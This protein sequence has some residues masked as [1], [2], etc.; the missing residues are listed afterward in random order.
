MW[1]AWAALDKLATI[2][3]SNLPDKIKRDF[4][5]ATVEFVLIYGASTW[6]LTKRLLTRL[7]GTYTRMLRVVL[8]ISWR[9][10]PTKLR[11]YGKVPSLSNTI[12]K[13]RMRFAGHSFRSKDELVSEVITWQ[14]THGKANVGRPHK[15]YHQQI[16]EDAGCHNTD[17]LETMMQDRDGWRERIRLVRENNPTVFD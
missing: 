8:N 17:E 1:K 12:I 15:T 9:E 11:L 3:K 2:W 14:P 6:T 16:A 13:S 7:D 5:R 4:F 10:H